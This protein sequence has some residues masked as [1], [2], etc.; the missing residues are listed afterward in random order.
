MKSP[1][2]ST[3]ENLIRQNHKGGELIVWLEQMHQLKNVDFLKPE[4]LK[5]NAQT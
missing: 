1:N 3:R 5:Q 2:T 4:I